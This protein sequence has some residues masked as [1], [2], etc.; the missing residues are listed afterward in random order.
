MPR[1]KK[2]NKRNLKAFVLAEARKLQKEAMAKKI[3]DPSTIKADE[4][5]AGDEAGTI[6]KDIDFIKALNIHEKRVLKKLKMI[7]EHKRKL[8]RNLIKKL[9]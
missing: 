1:K 2:L 8:K 6:E 5:E 7:R 9:Q 3:Q 4:Y